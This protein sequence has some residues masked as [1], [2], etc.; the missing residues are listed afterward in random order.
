M[1]LQRR[2]TSAS[3]NM[4]RMVGLFCPKGPLLPVDSTKIPKIRYGTSRVIAIPI[5][6]AEV[7]RGG[8]RGPYCYYYSVFDLMQST[9]WV[10]CPS[11]WILQA[12]GPHAWPPG[13]FYLRM[14]DFV[15]SCRA[16]GL[17]VLQVSRMG[18]P[19]PVVVVWASNRDILLAC[20]TVQ[21]Q[22]GSAWCVM[23]SYALLSDA[24]APPH[25]LLLP[26]GSP[27]H[28]RIF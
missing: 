15:S 6:A 21:A 4:E 10:S 2:D 22:R 1:Q 24:T 25:P 5:S 19:Y 8:H 16:G 28:A 7:Y 20:V 26:R 9:F 3:G 13:A 11:E 12:E 18:I 27:L 14:G 23:M 17:H